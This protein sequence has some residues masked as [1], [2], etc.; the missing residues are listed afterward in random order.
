MISNHNF[1]KIAPV[2]RHNLF[3]DFSLNHLINKIPKFCRN[4]FSHFF[5]LSFFFLILVLIYILGIFEV[6]WFFFWHFFNF[7][8]EWNIYTCSEFEVIH[9]HRGWQQVNK[10]A[11][12]PSTDFRSQENLDKSFDPKESICFYL[13]RPGKQWPMYFPRWCFS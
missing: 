5:G 3:V 7:W 4:R 2:S 12:I 8:F 9:V 11:F 13:Q 10:V 1:K 6:F